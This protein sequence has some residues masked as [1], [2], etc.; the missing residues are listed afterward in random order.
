MN[1]YEFLVIFYFFA[2]YNIIP[3]FLLLKGK[4]VKCFCYKILVDSL[5]IDRDI[6]VE[7]FEV[8]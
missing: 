3:C 7:S 8:K 6:M 5:D 1:T 4:N 2:P